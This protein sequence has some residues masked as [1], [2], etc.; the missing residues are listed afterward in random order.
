MAGRA[1]SIGLICSFLL[2]GVGCAPFGA[3]EGQA[4]V[5]T[6]ARIYTSLPQF[7]GAVVIDSNNV[8]G[9]E[10]EGGPVTIGETLH[11]LRLPASSTVRE[12]ERFYTRRLLADGWRL[13]GRLPGNRSHNIGPVLNFVRGRV[14]VSVNLDGG[15]GH[16]MEL[17]V[18]VH[19]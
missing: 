19:A 9:R 17:A 4:L 18:S 15:Y 8:V 13:K 11:V 1:L 5:D 2:T 14:S 6:A 3:R 16:R 12:V 10:D 7:P